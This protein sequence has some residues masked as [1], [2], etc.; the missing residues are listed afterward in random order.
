MPSSITALFQLTARILSPIY[1]G[2]CGKSRPAFLPPRTKSS[3]VPFAVRAGDGFTLVV[4]P[5]TKRNHSIINIHNALSEAKARDGLRA[6]LVGVHPNP[7]GE[8]VGR[9]VAGT[10]RDLSR[11]LGLKYFAVNL[12]TGAKY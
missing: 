4:D 6:V 2:R 5:S 7:V 9:P 11:D 3:G 10:A 1:L 12:E 8:W